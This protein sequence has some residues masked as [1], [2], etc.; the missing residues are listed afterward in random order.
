MAHPDNHKLRDLAFRMIASIPN[1][2]CVTDLEILSI[3]T[4][5]HLC[6][7]RYPD[8]SKMPELTSLFVDNECPCLHSE[9]Y[10][11]QIVEYSD[12]SSCPSD[13][14]RQY[15]AFPSEV[16]RTPGILKFGGARIRETVMAF[17][18]ADVFHYI[19][20]QAGAVNDRPIHR[21][22]RFREDGEWREVAPCRLILK[23]SVKEATIDEK[24]DMIAAMQAA[25]KA[26]L[27]RAKGG[28]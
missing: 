5:N 4:V 12:P 19:A 14:I 13:F 24:A 2:F 6:H 11:Y 28:Q 18:I 7:S 20:S 10:K 26:K 17:T 23:S 27:E 16:E 9:L 22:M 8:I 3:E 25:W 15:G 21:I 1:V